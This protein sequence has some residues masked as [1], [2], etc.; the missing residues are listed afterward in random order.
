MSYLPLAA[1]IYDVQRQPR[2]RPAKL[3]RSQAVRHR[4][5]R[6]HARTRN[7]DGTHLPCRT[8]CVR[9]SK[10][11]T[12]F[13]GC[14]CSVSYSSRAPSQLYIFVATFASKCLQ[15]IEI[16]LHYYPAIL[17]CIGS[18]KIATVTRR[19]FPLLLNI[20]LGV[21][22]LAQTGIQQCCTAATRENLHYSI[23]FGIHRRNDN[24]CG[25]ATS[26]GTRISCF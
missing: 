17:A 12:R 6:T 11:T 3:H 8:E 10:T 7:V 18:I 13:T 4:C 16:T 1:K 15:K 26:L 24:A 5:T 23:L 21:A 22:T 20:A 9:D 2:L 14:A 25:V 19:P